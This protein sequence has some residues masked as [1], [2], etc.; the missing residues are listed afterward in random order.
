MLALTAGLAGTFATAA[1]ARTP[2]A[3]VLVAVLPHG[4]TV[5][6][7]ARVPGMALGLMS[8]GVGQVPARQT[9]L[10]ISQGNRI[11]PALYDSPP[12]GDW[13]QL[14]AR[15]AAAPADLV[16]GLLGST[17]AGAGVPV[18]ASVGAGDA[19]LIGVNE[20]G[21]IAKA[22][23]RCEGWR[24]TDGIRPKSAKAAICPG[25]TVARA[26][27]AQ[28][29][30][31]AT[32]AR[33]STLLV[34]VSAPPPAPEHMLPIGIAGAGLTGR[35]TSDSTHTDGLVLSTDVAPTLLDRL[36]IAV[37]GAMAG[38]PITSTGGSADPASLTT[39]DDRIA[40][41][42]GRRWSTIG[43]TALAWAGLTLLTGLLFGSRGFRRAVPLL[44]CAISFMPAVLLLAALIQP[45]AIVEVLM[46]GLGCPAL[47]GL[48]VALAGPWGGLA[49]AAAATVGS[50]A[51]A[52]IVDTSVIGL[53]L[54]GPDPAHGTRFYGIGNEIE[55]FAVALV[56]IGV[57]AAATR[58]R[59]GAPPGSIAPW[60]GLAALAVAA[61]F[62]PGL[63][64]ADV[65]AAIDLAVGAAVAI[66][67]CAPRSGRLRAVG[68]VV[69]AAAAAFG[70]LALVDLA[71]GGNSH[72]TRS[73][74]RA[75]GLDSLAQV[76]ERRLE[77]SAHN[78]SGYATSPAL[79][80]A[81]GLL[82]AGILLRRR[83]VGWFG[84]RRYAWA[85]YLGA[86]AG[87]AAAVLVNDAGA[88]VMMIGIAL[89]TLAAGVAWATCS[90]TSSGPPG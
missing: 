14:R 75:G 57:G 8:A 90:V 55:T 59:P 39:L 20:A 56:P 89:L 25:L 44:A 41:V 61:A 47:A 72:L 9:Y 31:F 84:D 66:I 7:L 83:I 43:L 35:L 49:T 37:P 63:F 33:G 77:L 19:A 2:S 12:T 13:A 22:S 24:E 70:V 36:G 34:A 86:L 60:F 18:R 64:G 80:A 29:R 51:L 5:G 27:L 53:S 16:P 26:S 6:D 65:G 3:R 85:G 50:Y 46:V 69:G 73:V 71:T 76:A 48:S 11:D 23:P 67:V 40:A 79:W 4:T 38:Q 82:V 45:S 28:V 21:K 17:L 32:K 88:I 87:V 78:F 58:W 42:P 81:V 68:W 62:A 10:D 15:A 74:L 52:A 1:G 54:I 30:T